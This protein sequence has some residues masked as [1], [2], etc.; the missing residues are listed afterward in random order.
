MV[1]TAARDSDF[2]EPP[3]MANENLAS[4]DLATAAEKNNVD[5]KL[6]D[7]ST[8]LRLKRRVEYA[9]AILSSVAGWFPEAFGNCPPTLAAFRSVLGGGPVLIRLRRLAEPR[10]REIPFPVGLNPRSPKP[11]DLECKPP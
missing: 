9:L 6:F 11:Q 8:E 10:I 5:G 3:A 2:D 1:E 4:L 7:R